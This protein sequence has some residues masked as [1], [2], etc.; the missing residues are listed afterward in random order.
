MTDP[1]LL[2]VLQKLVPQKDG[3]PYTVH[4]TALVDAVNSDGTVDILLSGVLIP[5]VPC[6]SGG[7]LTV[8]RAVNV[9]AWGGGLLVLGAPRTSNSRP[10]QSYIWT[11]NTTFVVPN[12]VSHLEVWTQAGGGAGGGR[13]SASTASVSGGGGGGGG[14]HVIITTVSPG[15]SISVVVGAGGTGV[16]AG[17][18]GNG[19]DSQFGSYTVATGGRGGGIAFG[20]AGTNFAAGGG[21]G[22]GA[23]HIGTGGG[24]Q[25]F[26]GQNG[27]QGYHWGALNTSFSQIGAGGASMF[28]AGARP[29]QIGQTGITAAG[30][31]WSGE[32]GTG[33]AGA[34]SNAAGGSGGS[35][36]VFAVAY[37]E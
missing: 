8:G 13:S 4:R 37:F 15:Q 5:G 6:V 21:N 27:Q 28:G 14:N 12:G 10:P 34:A 26:T 9:L 32:G 17:T 16:V 25:N 1:A 30:R 29:P 24:G 23:S 20:P 18:G 11:S 22:G 33:M 7:I 35:G 19:G 3:E 2:P 31:A 36:R